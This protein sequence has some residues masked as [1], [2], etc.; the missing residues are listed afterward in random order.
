M[1]DESR[2]KV[3]PPGERRSGVERREADE[4]REE[5]R[6]ELAKP[7]RRQRADRR[8]PEPWDGKLKR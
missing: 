8:K 1:N 4:R 5:I 7:V 2:P 3:R 6:F